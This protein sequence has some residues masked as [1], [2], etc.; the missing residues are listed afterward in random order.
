MR[1]EEISVRDL[2][3]GVLTV[4]DCRPVVYGGNQ[5]EYIPLPAVLVNGDYGQVVVKWRLTW[6]ERFEALIGG[7]IFHSQLTFKDKL[8]PVKITT[9]I[10]EMF[11]V[12]NN[13]KD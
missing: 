2:Q 5:P 13:D 9:A 8:Q 12:V 1:P 7:T 11:E 6:R 10:S 4:D 3:S